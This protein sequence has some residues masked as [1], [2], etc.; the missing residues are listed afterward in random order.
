MDA[1]DLGAFALFPKLANG[2]ERAAHSISQMNEVQRMESSALHSVI[3]F[4]KHWSLRQPSESV[5]RE[6]MHNFMRELASLGGFQPFEEKARR[7]VLQCQ[8]EIA[9]T[10]HRQTLEHYDTDTASETTKQLRQGMVYG[11]AGWHR[12]GCARA[13]HELAVA[14]GAIQPFPF[15]E[16][17]PELRN[18][19]Y[20]ICIPFG[21]SCIIPGACHHCSEDDP[22]IQPA[23][24]RISRD[25]RTESL[26]MFYALNK[27]QYHAL[28]YDFSH[29]VAH[30]VS[31]GAWAVKDIK[32]VEIFINEM[33]W[34]DDEN[35]RIVCG[36]GL[37]DLFRWYAST[38]FVIEL[39][40]SDKGNFEPVVGAIEA[41][42]KWRNQTP[43]A[44]HESR[45]RSFFERWLE[46]EDM[47]CSCKASTWCE[48]DAWYTCSRFTP[49]YWQLQE[50]DCKTEHR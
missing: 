16:L 47:N 38:K 21:Q 32:H 30:C 13:A 4:M 36:E 17:P 19:V 27:F 50:G 45:L 24:T 35:A 28:R 1:R 18:R 33:V 43:E 29:L 42:M 5:G 12:S 34:Y 41:A 49:S 3:Q 7:L 23:I 8:H 10:D 2:L 6:D 25:V 48:D 20:E 37:W 9:G 15:M 22:P 44:R 46:E 31:V 14:T 40:C 39:V 26:A 11:P